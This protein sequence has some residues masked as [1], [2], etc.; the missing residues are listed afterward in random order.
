MI[1]EI[2]SRR[3]ALHATYGREAPTTAIISITDIC[4]YK[5]KF[6]PQDWL[7]AILEIQFD[8]VTDGCR[9][10]ITKAQAKEIADFTKAVYHKVERIIV[11]CEYGQS[12]SAGVAAALDEFFDCETSEV[13]ANSAYSPNMTCYRYVMAA[14]KG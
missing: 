10:C 1:Y 11:H 9:G 5:N 3:E 13:F 7:I 14:L 12:R 8:D 4:A 2:M 6:C